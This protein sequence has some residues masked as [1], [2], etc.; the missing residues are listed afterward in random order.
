[1]P[2][3]DSTAAKYR[4]ILARPGAAT[5][6][7]SQRRLLQAALRWAQ[8]EGLLSA[9]EAEARR[10]AIAIPRQIR[11]APEPAPTAAEAEAFQAA[12][13]ALTEPR[14]SLLLVLL[15]LGLRSSELLLLSRD[16][17]KAAVAK[18]TVLLVRK[19]AIEQRL[20][21]AKQKPL[22]EALLRFRFSV[23]GELLDDMGRH[24]V[25]S[26]S[27]AS[28]L[29]ALERLVK[30]TGA[31][32]GYD[33]HPHSLRHACALQLHRDGASLRQ[34]QVWLNHQK[35]ETTLR[36]LNIDINEAAE[37]TRA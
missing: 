26:P 18:G 7:V 10:V 24:H 36:Y 4:E 19:G 15:R 29:R 8:A 14:R 12:A 16:E 5:G 9:E 35:V 31:K 13:E 22:F 28:R 34:I 21:M 37:F 3:L 33:W 27:T 23:V 2:V 1:M 6:P 20:P 30:K 25:D 11:K 32:S 17:I